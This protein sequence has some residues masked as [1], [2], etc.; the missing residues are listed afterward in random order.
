MPRISVE[1]TAQPFALVRRDVLVGK[2]DRRFHVGEQIDEAIPNFAD[3]RAETALELFGRG[4]EREIGPRADHIDHGFGLREVHLAVPER[5]LREL[6]RAGRARPR[7]QAR[8]QHAGRHEHAPM[9]ADLHQVVAG[10]AVRGAMHGEHHLIDEPVGVSNPGSN[11]LA[12]VL[13]VRLELRRCLFPAK[14]RIRQRNRL[15]P[16]DPHH[17]DGT[18]ADGGGNRG[19]CFARDGRR[20]LRRHHTPARFSTSCSAAMQR[21]FCS[22]VPTEMRTHS[23][24]L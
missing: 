11:N 21:R 3:C 24:R 7:L 18:L 19:D 2:I 4:T 6:T 16:R 12:E 17:R 14:D 20:I 15:R 23:G 10:V 9:A 13:D 5:A 8:L 1:A 22:I